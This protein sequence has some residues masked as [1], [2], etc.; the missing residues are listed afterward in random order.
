M[1]VYDLSVVV[2]KLA[3]AGDGRSEEREGVAGERRERVRDDATVWTRVWYTGTAE[4]C[5]PLDLS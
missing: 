5:A 1:R 2:V 4:H 3:V